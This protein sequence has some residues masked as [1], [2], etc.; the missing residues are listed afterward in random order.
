M[1]TTLIS[2]AIFLFS[3]I[4]LHA[5]VSGPY[6]P[7]MFSTSGNGTSWANLSGIAAVDNNPAYADLAQYPTCTNQ[8]CYYSNIANFKGF[9]FSVPSNAVITGIKLDIMQRVNSPGGGIHDSL[10][11]LAVG[12]S[13]LGSDYANDSNWFDTPH[14]RSYGGQND[15]WGYTWTPAEVNDP[16]FG[17]YYQLTNSSYDQTASVDHLEMSVYYQIGN[18]VYQATSSSIQILF[19]NNTLYIDNIE[20]KGSRIEVLN[21]AGS[22]IFESITDHPGSLSIDAA[23]WDDGI[24]LINILNSDHLISRKVALVH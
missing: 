14:I 3:V 1:K 7:V 20:Q 12:A 18:A 2:C 9:G 24:Y 19:L 16:D 13:M 10:L 6:E 8:L 15:K 11:N 22:R 23:N 4:H 17:F 21:Q 5:Q